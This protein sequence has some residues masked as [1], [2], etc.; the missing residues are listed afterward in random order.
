MSD[1]T[2]LQEIL[3]EL[4]ALRSELTGRLDALAEQQAA[5]AEEAARGLERQL[6]VLRELQSPPL[7]I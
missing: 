2:V 4:Q 3:A 5:S 6:S 1:E 7:E